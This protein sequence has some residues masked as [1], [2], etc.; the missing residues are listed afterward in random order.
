MSLST[1]SS[2]IKQLGGYGGERIENATVSGK[3]MAIHAL[4]DCT[5]GPAT[6]G[7]ISNLVGANVALGDVIVGEWSVIEI[8]GDA[9]V[10]YGS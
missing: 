9:I 4:A 1:Q 3:F 2:L 6:Q 7:S 10:Y 8:A 5:I